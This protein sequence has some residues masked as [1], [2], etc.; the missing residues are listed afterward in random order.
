VKKLTAFLAVVSILLAPSVSMGTAQTRGVFQWPVDHG[1]LHNNISTSFGTNVMNVVNE[2][3]GSVVRFN[4]AQTIH[5]IGFNITAISAFS[6]KAE[7]RIETISNTTGLPTGT[8]VGTGTAFTPGTGWTWVDMTVDASLSADTNYFVGTKITTYTSGSY[9][10]GYNLNVDT[11]PSR[12]YQ[13]AGTTPGTASEFGVIGMKDASGNV[14]FN[15]GS[16]PMLTAPAAENFA[17]NSNPD[18]RGVRFK[19]PFPTRL[20][21]MQWVGDTDQDFS[22]ILYDTNGTTALFTTTFDKDEVG[23]TGVRT[24]TIPLPATSITKDAFYRLVILPG[25]TTANNWFYAFTVGE[26]ADLD[27]WA[28]GQNFHYTEVNGAPSVEGD[29]TNTTTK[30]AF[31]FTLLFDQFDDAAGGGGGTTAYTFVN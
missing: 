26:A 2:Y 14:L 9:T 27:G 4:A 7:I 8:K 11:S 6:G 21:G 30:Q 5:S 15:L 29:W 31:G 12:P 17:S 22:V 1:F 3:A 20:R 13:L 10:Q 24:V 16:A 23:Q 28:G 19:F 18:R 25:S